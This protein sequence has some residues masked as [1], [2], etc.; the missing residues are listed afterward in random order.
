[1]FG[2]VAE[3]AL[4]IE[5]SRK[6]ANEAD[7]V[8]AV[9]DPLRRGLLRHP[10]HEHLGDPGGPLLRPGGLRKL[11]YGFPERSVVLLRSDPQPRALRPTLMGQQHPQQRL[12][13]VVE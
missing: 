11:C 1:M 7:R 10:T 8:V 3:G 13:R 2:G 9:L 4:V 12:N 5:S 6:D